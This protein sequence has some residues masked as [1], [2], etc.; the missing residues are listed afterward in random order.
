M[1][2]NYEKVVHFNKSC[3]ILVNDTPQYNIFN[4]DPALIR[5][6]VQLISEEI[7]ETRQGFNKLD[8]V[9]IADGIADILYVTYGKGCSI[10]SNC[11][12]MFKSLY[13]N[14]QS[15]L[16]SNFAISK[17]YYEDF[18]NKNN[19]SNESR[20]GYLIWSMENDLALLKTLVSL[21]NFTGVEIALCNIILKCYMIGYL[22]DIDVDHIFDLV[23]EANMSKVCKTEEEAIETVNKYKKDL[24]QDPEFPYLFPDYKLS[25]NKLYYIIYNNDTRPNAKFG[26]KILKSIN[27]KEADL[28]PYVSHI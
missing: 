27:W 10:G 12:V 28:T 18:I 23:H 11:D 20:L 17:P 3:D 14:K 24:E 9:E 2:S 5:Y 19:V 7:K 15:E 21:C 4:E 22:I 1:L 26:G 6:R 13:G 16:L 8:P 25:S